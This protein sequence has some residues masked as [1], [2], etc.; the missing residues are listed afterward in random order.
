MIRT[1]P[2]TQH[3]STCFPSPTLF[4]TS[5]ENVLPEESEVALMTISLIWA[6]FEC[7]CYGNPFKVD[8]EPSTKNWMRRQDMLSIAENAIRGGIT[9][10]GD[11][12]SIQADMHLCGDC[13]AVADEIGRA[14]C[15]ERVCQYV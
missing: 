15:R 11:F 6:A 2:N 5:L 10:D 13:T 3:S 14:S 12:C 9:S 1:H 8:I 7:D 4:R